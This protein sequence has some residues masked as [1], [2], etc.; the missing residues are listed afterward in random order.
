MIPP[1]SFAA[2]HLW[3]ST[4]F[5]AVAGILTLALRKNS[6]QTRYCVW[7]AAS[8]K[9]LLPAAALVA[10]GNQVPWRVAPVH[11]MQIA[12]TVSEIRGPFA[13]PAAL[14]A[15]ARR[16]SETPN[17]ALPGAVSSIWLCGVVG[18]TFF[19][20]RRWGRLSTIV[21]EASPLQ[22]GIGVEARST[23][24]LVEPGV[25]GIFRPI[26]LL[27]AGI[28]GRLTPPQLEAVIAHELCHVRRRDNLAAAI[29]M[30][31]EAV[32]WFHPMVWWLGAKMV[33]ERERA[34]DE[35][36]LRLGGEPRE[37]AEGILNVC[38]FYLESPLPCVSGVTGAGLKQRITEIMTPRTTRGL[39]SLQKAVLALAALGAVS[40]PLAIGIVNAPPV[41]AQVAQ[42]H[43]AFEVA[44]VKP[45]RS[46]SP[47]EPFGF[48]PTGRIAGTNVTLR[49]LA[50]A[51]Y[52]VEP[53][54]LTGGPAWLD[55]E[56]YDIEARAEAGAVP[57]GPVTRE[58]IH[59]MAL[60]LQTLLA[61]RFKLAVHRETKEGA[62]YALV[63]AKN[64]PKLQEVKGTDCKV[65]PGCGDFSRISP[66]GYLSGP[67]VS[68]L[69]LAD[70]LSRFIVGRPVRDQTGINGIFN[71]TLQ[72]TR[73]GYKPRE[74]G[75]S[76]NEP[77]PD[78]NG[79]SLFAALQEQLG[80]KLEAQKGSIETIVIDHAEKA[81]ENGRPE[82]TP[83]SL[84]GAG[85]PAFQVV[86]IKPSKDTPPFRI[87]T[88]FLPSGR[89]QAFNVTAR[90]LVEMAYDVP[91]FK[92][93]V[94][95]GQ[96]WLDSQRFNIE[97]KA[98]DGVITPA[99]PDEARNKLFRQ[100]LQSFLAERMKLTLHSQMKEVPVYAL[101]VDKNG[102]KLTKATERDCS[103]DF[104]CHG[105]H[106]GRARGVT[107]QT[108]S[109]EDLAGILT[110]FS[111]RV[112]KDMTGI[113][114]NFDITLPVWSD[115][116]RPPSQGVLEGREPGPDPS[117][118]D[119][120]TVLKQTLGLKLESRK[121]TI[122]TFAIDRLERPSEN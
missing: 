75:V 98:E 103:G 90:Q 52:H 7:L 49:R 42:K 8:L 78:G 31:V 36:V 63:V 6:A 94:T 24:A 84:K 111:D 59:Q 53:Y 104:A 115:P 67:M 20:W 55:S 12:G 107:G 76:N 72:W 40:M 2:N 35:E 105:F 61:D 21:H 54:R 25:F 10:L 44:S 99:M 85:Q 13:K 114:G 5:A 88:Q 106:G 118:P 73:E 112:V 83:A 64:G 37:Y 109:T 58:S 120:F 32:F 95:G 96:E 4:A 18:V 66:N 65:T 74:D 17:M 68:V 27:P 89:L 11:T 87:G 70:V 9:F 81:S 15:P 34:C 92:G 38:Q 30:V 41:R 33:E 110:A 116:L 56:H 97:A 57:P 1:L 79:P 16:I 29:H 19:W 117:A 60:M 82:L 23:A 39:S 26:L 100:M 102:P 51:A 28:A 62:I 43:L 122:E 69:D 71:V 50:E 14:G 77:Q 45:N 48:L 113:N 86:S 119:I 80:L 46:G 101:L 22:L 121:A 91:A 93:Y 47:R 3:Q 108:V